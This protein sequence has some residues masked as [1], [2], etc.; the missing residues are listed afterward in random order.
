MGLFPMS[1][2]NKMLQ[3]LDARRTEVTGTDAYSHQIRAVP[4]RRRIHVS[5]WIALV[6]ALGLIGVLA[7]VLLRPA[8]AAIPAQVSAPPQLALKLH[9]DLN[10]GQPAPQQNAAAQESSGVVTKTDTPTASKQTEGVPTSSQGNIQPDTSAAVAADEAQDTPSPAAKRT[11][12]TTAPAQ[13]RTQPKSTAT[14]PSAAGDK[15]VSAVKPAVPAPAS[16]EL[17]TTSVS[18]LSKVAPE[19][20]AP[21]VPI[22]KAPDPVA[23][24]ALNKQIRELTPVQRAE[25]EYR[26]A[27]V[28]MQQG[29][30]TEALP[31]LEQ[32]LQLDPKHAAVRQAL[33]KVFLD[34][35]RQDD[36]LRLAREGLS[37]NPAHPGLAMISARLQLESGDLRTAVDT[38]ERTLPYAS[39]RADYRSFLAALLQRD[40]RNK[41]AAEHYLLALQSAPQN[42][43]WW[44]GLGISL[45]A[46]SR[47]AE[48][49]ES[50][51]RA[52]E[53]NS[54][55]PELLAF[56]E[57]KLKQLQR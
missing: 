41:E 10:A 9:T 21:A 42:G 7:W 11:G 31:G 27:V 12:N 37:L 24:V 50:F 55:S 26:K 38:L 46:E 52:K 54:L 45:Q 44:M 49:K 29:R 1:L 30:A 19:E 43:V 25:N 57:S 51:S 35:K 2:I 3:D 36:A 56:V 15:P 33:A 4:A 28:L 23:S 18:N 6:L 34:N 16:R 13:R 39:D 5:W 8:P 32:A 40:G 17:A 20:K 48:A 14:A 22:M 47:L 53:T